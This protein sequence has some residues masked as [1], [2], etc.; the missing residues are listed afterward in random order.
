MQ[1]A[2]RRS[3]PSASAS[4]A[5][6]TATATA[7]STRRPT[8]HPELLVLRWAWAQDRS[9]GNVRMP[10]DLS[11]A[12]SPS[13]SPSPSQPDEALMAT[14]SR[15][16]DGNPLRFS[17]LTTVVLENEEF[18]LGQLW[19]CL[20]Y[21]D[22]PEE[23]YYRS[24]RKYKLKRV[25]VANRKSVVAAMEDV[26][27]RDESSLAGAASSRAPGSSSARSF[28]VP[29]R[30]RGRGR[31]RK[32]LRDDDPTCSACAAQGMAEDMISCAG[33]CG[34]V[35]H[36]L[37]A[38]HK[39]SITQRRVSRVDG[40]G[41]AASVTI[42]PRADES[43]GTD[44]VAPA[45]GGEDVEE[46]DVWW[47][48]ECLA[49]APPPAPAPASAPSLGTGAEDS[50]FKRRRSGGTVGTTPA[51]SPTKKKKEADECDV[52]GTGG[53]LLICENECGRVFHVACV[54]QLNGK[55]PEGTWFCPKCVDPPHS[56]ATTSEAAVVT[57][58]AK[59][60][61]RRA[62]SSGK[63]DHDEVVGVG[64]GGDDDIITNAHEAED[65]D[66][67]EDGDAAAE[68]GSDSDSADSDDA[69]RC[70]ACHGR[71]QVIVCENT[72]CTRVYHVACVPGL[73]KVPK[74]KWECPKCTAVRERGLAC[75]V[76]GKEGGDGKLLVCD[77]CRVEAVHL[78]CIAA[79]AGTASSSSSPEA[80][81]SASATGAP[82]RVCDQ[83]MREGVANAATPRR[84]ARATIRFKAG[85][86]EV[87]RAR[88]LQILAGRAF[89]LPFGTQ[90]AFIDAYVARTKGSA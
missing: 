61:R 59:R 23:E 86:P 83:R 49:S 45:G 39:G 81:G 67:D 13:P 76:C 85:T 46:D 52:C 2:S 33:T 15:A 80:G 68:N 84:M 35:F 48:H 34:R 58:P 56:T 27:L 64:V 28:L 44:T 20:K 21:A 90:A 30:K 22:E 89:E 12:A 62:S 29:R 11:A 47:C 10:E 31:P 50:T 24:A 66:E 14:V 57:S 87:E 4:T 77:S 55:V 60:Q 71:G 16:R 82:C 70:A 36:P 6:A 72:G 42:V 75:A 54:P 53:E 7:T 1:D 78:S 74:G 73:D 88:V 18:T 51:K 19:H 65:E 25:P 40:S 37:C 3:P 38:L 5:T 41:Q 26:P 17:P 43:G 79:Y 69:E 63:K 32:Y 9:L 8:H